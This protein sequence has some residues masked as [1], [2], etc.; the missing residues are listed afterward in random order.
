MNMLEADLTSAVYSPHNSSFFYYTN[1]PP[2][3]NNVTTVLWFPTKKSYLTSGQNS[4]DVEAA[5]RLEKSYAVGNAPNQKQLYNLY[6]NITKD[7][8]SQYN[9]KTN[10]SAYNNVSA[11][12]YLLLENVCGITINPVSLHFTPY[13]PGNLTN[14][15]YVVEIIIR[16]IDDDGQAKKQYETSDAPV[17]TFKRFVMIDQ[18]QEL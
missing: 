2:T 3:D 7:S 4:L 16:V 6:Y 5:Y 14:L 18:G 17:R 10:A 15:P 8:D 9:Y 1:T 13:N 12:N 11:T